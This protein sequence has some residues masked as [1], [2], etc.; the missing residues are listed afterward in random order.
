MARITKE[1][2]GE[3]L[4]EARHLRV[5]LAQE[6]AAHSETT[7]RLALLMDAIVVV[8]EAEERYRQARMPGVVSSL[9]ARGELE[10]KRDQSLDALRQCAAGIRYLELAEEEAQGG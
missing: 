9:K 10:E 6:Q 4:T 5:L 2:G 7:R 1:G 8:V 3:H